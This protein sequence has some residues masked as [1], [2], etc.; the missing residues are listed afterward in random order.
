MQVFLVRARPAGCARLSS[1]LPFDEATTEAAATHD[2]AL[3]GFAQAAA[4]AEGYTV[5]CVAPD[6]AVR[7]TLVT[8][9][10]AAVPA[11]AAVTWWGHDQPNDLALADALHMPP[12]HR[13]LLNMSRPLPLDPADE[14]VKV[15]VTVQPF[16][17]GADD[18]AWLQVNNA[19]FSWHEEQSEWNLAT[20]RQR[21]SEPWFD[22]A[23]LLVHERDGRL[24][25]F[26]WT[27]VHA[28]GVGEIYVIAVH[29]DFHG[30]GLGRALTVAG[31]RHLAD[32][33]S[34]RAMLYVEADNTAAVHLYE[35]LGFHVAH[36]DVA[37]H[38][39]ANQQQPPGDFQ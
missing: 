32:T 5:D 9:L 3:V 33:G 20:L 29:P 39:P 11:D 23:G 6:H 21:M 12:P 22:P 25:A 28:A 10:V 30:L 24:A 18:V 15:E 13:R 7:E 14:P 26:C 4:S 8:K 36:V 31:L 2:A 35:S 19:A 34:T 16:K 27:K 17:V 1:A 38:R 37:F